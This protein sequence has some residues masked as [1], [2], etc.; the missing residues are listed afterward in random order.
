MSPIQVLPRVADALA[1]GRAVVALES[2]LISHGLPSPDNLETARAMEA[3]VEAAGAT[4]AT[5]GICAGRVYV[6]CDDALLTHLAQA[7][8]IHKVSRRDL[9]AVIAR[10]G[11]GGTTV[12]A[13]MFCAAKVGIAVL[14]TGGIGGVHRGAE[15][16]WDVSADLTEL[17][18]TPVAVVCSGA[19]SILDLPKTVE[20]LETASVPVIGY[21][22]HVLPAFHARDSGLTL[23][24]SVETP[25]AAAEIIV[26]HRALGLESGIVF[27]NPVPE[28]DA[29]PKDALDSWIDQAQAEASAHGVWGKAL[30]PFLLDRIAALSGGRTLV[31]NKALLQHNATV[32]AQIAVALARRTKE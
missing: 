28:T 3:A 30:T 9:A 13:T 17:G 12:A 20:A 11:D 4:P 23:D 25:E 2:S 29:I 18:R 26:Q 14:A 22:T 32:G 6:G 24:A 19:K 21:G 27:A 7:K 1:A 16:T 10:D 31:A 5:I 15:A 8:D